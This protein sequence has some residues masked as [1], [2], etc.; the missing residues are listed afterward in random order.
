MNYNIKF[1][2]Q[3]KKAQAAKEA[4]VEKQAFDEIFGQDR[5]SYEKIINSPKCSKITPCPSPIHLEVTQTTP[6]EESDELTIAE[7]LESPI[8]ITKVSISILSINDTIGK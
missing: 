1:K 3:L 6:I 8:M 2:K 7:N 5:E 4:R